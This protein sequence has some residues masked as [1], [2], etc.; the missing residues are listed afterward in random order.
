MIEKLSDFHFVDTSEYS[1]FID[2]FVSYPSRASAADGMPYGSLSDLEGLVDPPVKCLDPAWLVEHVRQ[3]EW[4]RGRLGYGSATWSRTLLPGS[5]PPVV[6]KAPLEEAHTAILGWAEA[7]EKL[8]R[9]AVQSLCLDETGIPS[10]WTSLGGFGIEWSGLSLPS[11]SDPVPD[12]STYDVPDDPSPFDNFVRVMARASVRDFL[13]IRL[14]DGLEPDDDP[15]APSF[16]W[17]RTGDGGDGLWDGSSVDP[18]LLS[19]QLLS[20]YSDCEKAKT[21]FIPA[22]SR[23]PVTFDFSIKEAYS[24]FRVENPRQKVHKDCSDGCGVVTVLPHIGQPDMSNW[25]RVNTYSRALDTFYVPSSSL[26]LL[27]VKPSLHLV[28]GPPWSGIPVRYD[29]R[30][31]DAFK[32][33]QIDECRDS[34]C[35]NRTFHV[36]ELWSNKGETKYEAMLDGGGF[37]FEFEIPLEIPD[38][39]VVE[40]LWVVMVARA[41]LLKMEDKFEIIFDGDSS[42]DSRKS[43]GTYKTELFVIAAEATYENGKVRVGSVPDVPKPGN[44]VVVSANRASDGGSA[45][46][47]DGSQVEYVDSK[48]R[49]GDFAEIMGISGMIASL[50]FEASVKE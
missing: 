19:K 20:M 35:D 21:I 49:E 34:Q 9:G 8:S 50:K 44:V 22:R 31:F 41:R 38:W 40:R 4:A 36:S 7:W 15:E 17:K 5:Q 3:I 27:Y 13:T 48:V 10:S 39:I 24:G 47:T 25:D 43:S 1:D 11:V 32:G 45:E 6:D 46:E 12:P 16:L 30:Y 26:E 42:S 28:A 23:S 29:D 37:E 33:M 18:R 2:E 14:L